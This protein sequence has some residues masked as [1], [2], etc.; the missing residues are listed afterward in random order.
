[1]GLSNIH[2]ALKA[3]INLVDMENSYVEVIQCAFVKYH[4]NWQK[5][6]KI[7]GYISNL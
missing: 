1:M 4:H 3:F 7:W 5:K 2:C 6:Q